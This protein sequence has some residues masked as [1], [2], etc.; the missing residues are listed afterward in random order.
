MMPLIFVPPNYDFSETPVGLA[1][2]WAFDKAGNFVGEYTLAQAKQEG[3]EGGGGL[4]S[5]YRT[6]LV[7]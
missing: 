2:Y 7:G 3:E 5:S 1:V 6:S 4:Q